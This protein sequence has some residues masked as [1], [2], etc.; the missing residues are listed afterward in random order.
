[1]YKSIASFFHFSALEAIFH[2]NVIS[3]DKTNSFTA[4][5]LFIIT[6]GLIDRSQP[7]S[8]QN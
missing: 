6:L 8:N 1:M 2:K 4:L 7:L 5:K 3:A